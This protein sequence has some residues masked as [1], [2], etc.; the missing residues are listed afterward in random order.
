MTIVLSE[1]DRTG[2][3]DLYHKAQKQPVILL[4]GK[5]DLNREAWDHVKDKLD[6]LGEKYG[7]DPKTST[8]NQETGEVQTLDLNIE[9]ETSG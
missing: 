4:F 8:V 7:Y 6:E 1:E 5:Y 9:K 3:V 2:L